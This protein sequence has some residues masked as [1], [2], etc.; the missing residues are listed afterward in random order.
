MRGRASGKRV[1]RQAQS[2]RM[3]NR[4]HSGQRKDRGEVS[5]RWRA[6]ELL[7]LSEEALC[8]A[9]PDAVALALE[10]GCVG[11][12]GNDFADFVIGKVALVTS[13]VNFGQLDFGARVGMV[14]GN[15]LP[16]FERCVS[17]VKGGQGFGESHQRIPVIMF[18]VFGDDAF[19]KR[20]RLRWTFRAK[21]ALAKVSA[22][23]DVLRIAF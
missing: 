16:D 6:N 21:E 19:E 5:T 9:D 11:V 8:A 3:Q 23:V 14:L 7:E 18:R 22:S 1:S 15:L 12:I 2:W 20:A 10:S 17:F 4:A 13:E